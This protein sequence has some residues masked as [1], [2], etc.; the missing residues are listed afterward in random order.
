MEQHISN[1]CQQKMAMTDQETY[2]SSLQEKGNACSLRRFC[3]F[4]LFFVCLTVAVLGAVAGIIFFLLK[5][6]K[7][8]FSLHTLR[9]DSYKLEESSTSDLYLSSN[10]SLMLNAW[11]N[12]KFGI[13]YDPSR[14]SVLYRG[15]PIGVGQMPS[16]YQPEHSQN[17]SVEMQ[18][19]LNRLNLR[20]VAKE[21][22][23]NNFTSTNG[24]VQMRVIGS[25]RAHARILHI[26]LPK[27]KVAVD[28]QIDVSYEDIV[29]N[30]RAYESW[31]SIKATS[32][33]FPSL[34]KKC[35]TELEI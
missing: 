13:G 9:F 26:N 28:C 30:E 17:V 16:F 6:R 23:L 33:Y 11:N 24:L 15:I 2:G 4:L 8:E 10:L 35:S 20:Q 18:F 22:F 25:V 14:Y 32:M 5:P 19:V 1:I 29:L 34:K 3:F 31:S 21:G 12:N 7:P 27:V